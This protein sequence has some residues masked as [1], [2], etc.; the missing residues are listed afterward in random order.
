M[1]PVLAAGI[2]LLLCG[3]AIGL[4]AGRGLLEMNLDDLVPRALLSETPIPSLTPVP[5]PS[6]TPRQASD[7]RASLALTA[8][9]QSLTMTPRPTAFA[10]PTQPGTSVP[11]ITAPPSPTVTPRATPTETPLSFLSA[12]PTRGASSTATGTMPATITASPT[13]EFDL[14]GVQVRLIS[15]ENGATMGPAEDL[16]GSYL[17]LRSG[18]TIHALLQPYTQSDRWYPAANL[19]EVPPERSSG[20][21]R[22]SDVRFRVDEQ[23]DGDV[24]YQLLMVVANNEGTRAQ[25]AAAVEGGFDDLESLPAELILLPPTTLVT[26]QD[27]INDTM[28]LYSQSYVGNVEIVVARPDGSAPRRLTHTAALNERYPSL[29]PDGLRIAFVDDGRLWTAASNGQNP[30]MLLTPADTSVKRPLWSPDGRFIAFSGDR[31]DDSGRNYYSQLFLYDVE[32]GSTVQ[33]TDDFGMSAFPS[34]LAQVE[35][36]ALIYN[37]LFPFE[38]G[39]SSYGLAKMIFEPVDL[40]G[41][42]LNLDFTEL[43]DDPNGDET[44]P[45]VSGDGTK[46]AY[47]FSEETGNNSEIRVLDLPTGMIEPVTAGVGDGFPIW[48]PD[49][50]VLYFESLGESGLPGVWQSTVGGDRRLLTEADDVAQ[51]PFAGLMNAV[52]SAEG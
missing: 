49:G 1:W 44:Q 27:S 46:V 8:L 39:D 26:H 48:H 19:F 31:A 4:V 18:W 30:E 20:D 5:T 17:N 47:V 32:G 7:N 34:W 28:L 14:A 22:I 13:L 3:A 51:K 40:S 23:V 9:W 36:Y 42:V 12:S 24:G 10:I 35:E 45:A 50:A 41:S 21:W 29:S 33:L 52:F 15:P 16:S 43:L 2:V 37:R 6:S 38:T 25:L 11:T